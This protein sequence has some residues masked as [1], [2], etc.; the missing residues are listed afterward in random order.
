MFRIF[1]NAVAPIQYAL[2]LRSLI[3]L[4][5]KKYHDKDMW[6]ER[7]RN[8]LQKGMCAQVDLSSNEFS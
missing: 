4:Y 8:R 5:D 7:A 2:S 6:I 3:Q 1:I